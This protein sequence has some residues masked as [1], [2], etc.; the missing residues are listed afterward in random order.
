MASSRAKDKL[1]CCA[2]AEMAVAKVITFGLT[3]AAS[4]Q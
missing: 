3:F 2:H 1:G 4:I